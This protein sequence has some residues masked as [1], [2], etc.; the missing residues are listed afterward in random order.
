MVP[1]P[2]FGGV[3]CWN[4]RPPKSARGATVRKYCA[5]TVNVPLE[6]ENEQTAAEGLRETVSMSGL[7]AY[8]QVF[9]A[10][11]EKVGKRLQKGAGHGSRGAP[12]CIFT[13]LWKH[14]ASIVFSQ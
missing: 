12:D 10:G 2:C 6:S 13:V 5:F 1:T 11:G 14:V 8:L 3:A 4:A 9:R 7:T